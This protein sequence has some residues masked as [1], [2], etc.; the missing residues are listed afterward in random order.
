M[1]RNSRRNLVVPIAAS[2]VSV[3]LLVGFFV[4]QMFLWHKLTTDEF[5]G[6]ITRIDEQASKIF[7]DG[8]FVVEDHPELSTASSTISAEVQLSSQTRFIHRIVT[9]PSRE[10]LEKSPGPYNMKDLPQ[11]EVAGVLSDLHKDIWIRIIAPENIYGKSSFAAK[12]IEYTEMVWP[13]SV[14]Q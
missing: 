10:E 9:R 3:G 7:L 2:L 12:S 4:W 14:P 13:D 11:R 1:S 5:T 6:T 8:V